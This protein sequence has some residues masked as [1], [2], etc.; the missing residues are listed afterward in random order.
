MR[1][2][3]DSD[4]GAFPVRLIE[5]V[6][7]CRALRRIAEIS[8]NTGPGEHLVGVGIPGATECPGPRGTT[9]RVA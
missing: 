3:C 9:G 7:E 6:H 8:L 5:G 4:A 2:T 1:S